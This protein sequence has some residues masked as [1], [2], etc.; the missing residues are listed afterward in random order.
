VKAFSLI[1]RVL[2]AAFF[3]VAGVTH[4]TNRDFF[5][6][7]VPP[8]LPWPEMLV[9]VSGV[10]EMV[11][12]VMLLVTATM[13]LAAW[14]LIALLIAVFPANIHMA[15]N[16]EP[17]ALSGRLDGGVADP[18]AAAGGDGRDRL[19]VYAPDIEVPR[20]PK[21]PSMTRNAS[22]RCDGAEHR[23]PIGGVR[24]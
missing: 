3:V 23:S 5:T 13:R 24:Q 21:E 1:F 18:V 14:G 7:I 6:S 12:G 11:L 22:H 9:Y 4:F 17:S 8:Y 20:L 2:F 19:L 16:D 10:A 15:M